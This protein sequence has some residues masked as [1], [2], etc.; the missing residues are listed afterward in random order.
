M[1]HTFKTEKGELANIT[2]YRCMFE[3]ENVHKCCENGCDFPVYQYAKRKD[4][5]SLDG[6]LWFGAIVPFCEYHKLSDELLNKKNCVYE[7]YSVKV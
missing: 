3:S 4:N 2:Y 7:R 5:I 6:T 1:Q